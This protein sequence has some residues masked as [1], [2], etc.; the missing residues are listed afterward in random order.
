MAQTNFNQDLQMK[1]TGTGA[2][3][4]PTRKDVGVD[5]RPQTKDVG[6]AVSSF[7][8]QLPVQQKRQFEL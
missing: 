6:T 4:I 5:C 1:Y 8:N 7:T 3:K 2:Q